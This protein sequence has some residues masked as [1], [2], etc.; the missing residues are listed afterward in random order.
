[1]SAPR[2]Y[3]LIG[4]GYARDRRI[5]PL[6]GVPGAHLEVRRDFADG[7]LFTLDLNRATE[8]D[9]VADL[10]CRS[11]DW[12]LDVVRTNRG[13]TLVATDAHKAYI[14]RDTFDEVHA[15][16]VLE[17]LGEQGNVA[18]FFATFAPIYNVLKAGGYLCGT[19]PSIHSP[20]AWADPGHRRLLTAGTLGFLD[21][22][23]PLA[24][25]SSDY[26]HMNPCDF[27]LCSS[28]DD[29]SNLAFVLQALK[30]AR[31]APEAQS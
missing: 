14:R 26:R 13:M 22:T 4:C 9:F 7:E 18:S 24:P 6:R 15:Y 2:R 31:L 8:P 17:H 5:D 28:F 27:R 3:L 10:D 20:W 30:P 16:E 23:H 25:P 11:W 29:G 12:S 19:V 21:R 1:M